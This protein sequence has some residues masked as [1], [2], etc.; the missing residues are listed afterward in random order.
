LARS[1]TGPR[2]AGPGPGAAPLPSLA[3]ATRPRVWQGIGYRP[4]PDALQARSLFDFAALPWP[5]PA[6]PAFGW[7]AF[8]DAAGEPLIGAVVA[9]RSESSVMLHGPVVV[10]ETEPLEVAAQLVAAALD[11]AVAAGAGTVFARPQGLDRVWVRF[12]FVPVPESML[13]PGLTA[14]AGVGLYAW[15]GG[16][17]LWSLRE[18]ARSSE[19]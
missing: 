2:A 14:R 9:V 12:G 18:P 17:A 11:H 8:T 4:L 19:D 6:D 7:G 15:R 10:S 3:S 5:D 16:S 1:R 13:P